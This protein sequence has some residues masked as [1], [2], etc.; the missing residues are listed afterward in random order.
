MQPTP[1][2]SSDVEY[3]VLP[4][5]TSEVEKGSWMSSWTW[6]FWQLTRW[7]IPERHDLVAV[8]VTWDAFRACQSKVCQLQF[9]DFAYQQI[10]WFHITMEDSP[11]MAVGKTAQQLEQEQSN[12]SVVETARM[13]F[14]VL[15]KVGVL[16]TWKLSA[17]SLIGRIGEA[18][19]QLTTYS[20]TNVSV[21]L[22]WTI[23]W[24]VT[25]L[26]CFNSFKSE[27]S[28]M[29]VNGAPSSSCSLISFSATTWFVKLRKK[30]KEEIRHA[31]VN[32]VCHF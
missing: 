15:G 12:V 23:S 19:N 32:L 30:Q 25:M 26:A 1:H 28:R 11:L 16:W 29:A 17:I 21:S 31:N 9:A 3:S 18:V 14:H 4:R 6:L 24:S 22:V 5:R 10:L 8:R 7:P 20:N 2:M 13:A 27:A